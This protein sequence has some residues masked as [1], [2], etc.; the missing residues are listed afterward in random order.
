MLSYN[1]ICINNIYIITFYIIEPK[2]YN[3]Q[4]TYYK[5]I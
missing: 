4:R 3:N 2:G 5:H 1:I